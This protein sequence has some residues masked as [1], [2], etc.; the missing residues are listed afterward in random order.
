MLVWTVTGAA[1]T[2]EDPVTYVPGV[3]GRPT[4]KTS[5]VADLEIRNDDVHVTFVASTARLVVE[6]PDGTVVPGKD[7]GRRSVPP[8][9]TVAGRYAF[10][11]A[12][13][14]DFDGLVLRFEDPGREPS[15]DL[16]LTGPA[17]ELERNDATDVDLAA[18]LA[19]PGIDMTWSIERVIVGKDWPLPVGHKGGTLVPGARAETGH[20]FVG[21]VARVDV[22]RCDCPGGVLDQT[23]SARLLV[24]GRP[25][26]AAAAASSKAILN[27]QTFSEVLLVFHVPV[28]S[29]PTE[30]VL[31]VGPL[32]DADQQATFRLELD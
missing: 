1:I 14:P 17:P 5:L 2:N 9:S 21:V 7:L 4:A 3:Y 24:D 11:L 15:F 25:Y 16:P 20:R 10:P 32:D 12:A 30:A 29:T 8:S 6:L 23:G 18:D 22:G 31:Q 13:G 27:P 28:E 26:T 19:I